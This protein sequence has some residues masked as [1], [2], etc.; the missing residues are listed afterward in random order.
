MGQKETLLLNNPL[1]DWQDALFTNCVFIFRTKSVKKNVTTYPTDSD[2]LYT[3][4]GKDVIISPLS[5]GKSQL[6]HYLRNKQDIHLGSKFTYTAKTH[7]LRSN[8]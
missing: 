8:C 1:D 7:T 4:L 6:Y 3:S 5:F 2:F